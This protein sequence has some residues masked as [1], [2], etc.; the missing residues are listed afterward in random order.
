[1]PGAGIFSKK[2]FNPFLS[3]RKTPPGLFFF[4][5]F[6]NQKSDLGGRGGVGAAGD[7]SISLLARAVP[8]G[9]GMAVLPAGGFGQEQSH[10]T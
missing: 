3:P 5:N 10:G 2:P 7:G 6:S 9:F 1:M 8:S 4:Q